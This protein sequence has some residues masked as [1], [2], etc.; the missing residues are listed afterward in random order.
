MNDNS[1]QQ[2][3]FK[4]QMWGL[5]PMLLMVGWLLF[6]VLAYFLTMVGLKQNLVNAISFIPMIIAPLGCIIYPVKMLTNLSSFDEEDERDRYKKLA[7]IELIVGIFGVLFLGYTL[8]KFFV[9]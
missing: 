3:A 5:V 4:V 9:R 2:T 6:W 7:I 1:R 8:F